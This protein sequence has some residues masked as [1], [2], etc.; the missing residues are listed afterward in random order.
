MRAGVVQVFAL[1]VDLRPAELLGQALGVVQRAG[2][3]DVVALEISQLLKEGRI[4]LGLFVL[5]SQLVD[6]R[7]QGFGDELAAE[8]AEQ[9]A[10]VR[11]GAV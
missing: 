2:A 11:T 6:Q 4:G 9:A 7:Q 10:V 1:E 8:A 3:A 5:G